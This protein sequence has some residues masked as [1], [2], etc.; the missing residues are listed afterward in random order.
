MLITCL[1]KSTRLVHSIVTVH[2]QPR[3]SWVFC[4]SLN[5]WALAMKK[6][7]SSASP[8]QALHLYSQLQRQYHP[9]D[10]FSILFALK[11]CTHVFHGIN[12]IRH[13][14]AHLF[15]L[16]FG[17]NTYVATSL[18]HAYAIQHFHDARI[19][20]DEMPSRNAVTWNVMI[21]GFSRQGDVRNACTFFD[22][23]PL[24]DLGSWSAM[25]AGYMNNAC[26]REGLAL[27]RKMA[28][29]NLLKPDQMILCTV[30]SGCGLIGS[31]GLLL[32]KSV[33]GFATKIEW[34]L[35]VEVST[36]LMDLY[37]KHGLLSNAFFMFNMVRDCNVV[38]WTTLICGAA[39]NGY[40]KEA[41]LIFEKMMK[42]GEKPNELT[43]TGILTACVQAGMVEEGRR[44]FR[45]LDEFGLR[46]R[47]QH[48]GCMI[49]LFG[50]AGLLGDA[51]EVISTMPLEPNVV[52]WSSFLSSCKLHR[53]FKMAEKVIDQVMRMVQP[54]NDGGV[55]SLISDLYVLNGKW[56]EAERL[57]KYMCNHVRK[58][59]GSSCVTSGVL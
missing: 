20:F 57:R 24:R 11:S 56:T 58:V 26:W 53:Q 46:P 21:T 55:Y 22:D 52:I 10:S 31:A 47:I 48:Y 4:A 41:L 51:Y 36:C 14:H 39:Q 27:F 59:R 6:A 40:G 3:S 25:I 13:L 54:Q 8:L 12:I 2:Y 32:G 15:K 17:A 1:N 37:L 42:S 23:M 19:L 18:L 35:N 45:M 5:S 43:F 44:Y 16:G 38:T 34:E 29:D 50:K 28:G 9:V 49:D 7:S 33:H 30:L